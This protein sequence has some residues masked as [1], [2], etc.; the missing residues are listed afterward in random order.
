MKTLRLFFFLCA[1][2]LCC[3]NLQAQTSSPSESAIIYADSFL[4]SFRNN[5]ISQ[6]TDLSYPGVITYYGGSKNFREY[7]QRVRALS[8]TGSPENLMLIQIV[9]DVS[10]LQCVIKK[11]RETTLDGRKAQ[12]I[13]YMVGQSKDDG[14][15]W[16]FFDVAQNSPG[17]LAYIMPDISEKLT[18]PQREVIFETNM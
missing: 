15:S 3:K 10:E 5:D 18:V 9:H 4:N 2:S 17:N 8:N 6:Y 14:Q 11:T 13:S 7:V 1:V 16:K 12:I